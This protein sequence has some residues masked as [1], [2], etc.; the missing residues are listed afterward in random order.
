MHVFVTGATGFVGSAV[1]QELLRVGHTVTGLARSEASV[2][3]LAAAG[4]SAHPGDLTDTDSLIAGAKQADGVIHMGFIHDFSNYM[5]SV[6][7][8]R[9]AITALG[10]TLAGTGRPLLVTSGL[11]ISRTGPVGTENDPVDPAVPRLSEAAALPFAERD[12]R[13]SAV[14]L[15]PSVHGKGDH[16]F[17]PALIGIAREKGLSAY[18]GDGA[19]RWPGVHVDDAARLFV[20]A[21]EKGEAGARYHGVGDGGAAFRDIAAIIGKKLDLPVVSVTPEEAPGN[22]GWMANFATLDMPT[23]SDLT[24]QRLGW[25]PTGPSLLDDLAQGAYFDA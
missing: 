17:V 19:N 10:E 12:V 16:G 8:D 7:V 25:R 13:V 20:L 23:S 24:Q 5:A 18:V 11:A 2:A 15:A 9:Q 21:L 6:G 1:V 4:A 14:R 22:F 3:K